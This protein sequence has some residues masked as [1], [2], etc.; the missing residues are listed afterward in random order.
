MENSFTDT[1]LTGPG[2]PFLEVEWDGG[3]PV[4]VAPVVEVAPVVGVGTLYVDADTPPS[5]GTGPVSVYLTGR[6]DTWCK[7]RLGVWWPKQGL[8]VDRLELLPED[9]PPVGGRTYQLL[10]EPGWTLGAVHGQVVDGLGHVLVT[11]E[12][13]VVITQVSAQFAGPRDLALLVLV[14]V[15]SAAG[16][17]EDP[18]AAYLASISDRSIHDLGKE[19]WDAPGWSLDVG[20][21]PGKVVTA[22]GLG[23]PGTVG[24]LSGS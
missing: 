10:P 13:G 15:I 12:T 24:R 11:D 5:A 17:G 18:T 20:D 4:V 7:S 23:R 3:T 8:W 1:N 21:L 9:V 22:L 2:V 19:S 6:D 16:L 14:T